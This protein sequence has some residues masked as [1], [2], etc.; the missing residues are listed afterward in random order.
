MDVPENE[1]ILFFLRAVAGGFHRF[2]LGGTG[3]V[4][5]FHA[6]NV[7]HRVERFFMELLV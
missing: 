6:E 1:E 5:K 3:F 7:D 4:T 2:Q